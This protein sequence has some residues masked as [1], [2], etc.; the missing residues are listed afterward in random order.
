[1]SAREHGVLGLIP[2]KGGSTRLARKNVAPLGGR[3]LIA[4]AAE[5]ARESGVFDRLVLSSEDEAVIE[6]GRGI[7]L[8]A[9]F[10]RP[11]ALARD[12]A[13]VVDVAL[14]AL[15]ALEA[16]GER[17]ETL[18]ILLP[19]CPFRTAADI[20][21][22]FALFRSRDEKSLMSVSEFDHTP[23]AALAVGED[24]V[25]SPHFPEYFGRKS[26]EMPRA[27]RPN[28]AIHILD[29]A[30][31]REARS[32]VAPPVLAYVMPRARSVDIDTAEDLLLAEA[33]L[34]RRGRTEA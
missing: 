32:Y 26:Q 30:R 12:P 9:P 5:A 28:G 17:Y 11:A 29:V 2:A 20:R 6:A 15:D 22:A 24:A 19:T 10:V 18:A 23:F 7:G 4:W 21:E 14:H 3:P 1:M 34:A 31:F 25:I 33:L 13:G 8:D 27:Y 16:G